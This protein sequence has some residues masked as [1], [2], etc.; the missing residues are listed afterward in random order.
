M[1]RA[2]ATRLPRLQVC[3]TSDEGGQGRIL[4]GVIAAQDP[5]PFRCGL[6]A[7]EATV[8]QLETE[9]PRN[10]AANHR[11]PTRLPHDTRRLTRRAQRR[12]PHRSARPATAQLSVHRRRLPRL[13]RDPNGWAARAVRAILTNPRYTGHEVWGRQRRDYD[14]LD[15]TAPADGTYGACAG[16]LATAGSGH[17]SPRTRR[18]STAR[19][20]TES[21]APRAAC[22]VP[23]DAMRRATYCAGA[24]AAR[25]LRRAHDRG[26]TK[27]TGAATTAANFGA[28]DPARPLTIP[29][30]RVRARAASRRRARPMAG[31][32]LF[33]PEHAATT[34][35]AIV[36]AA[37]YDPAH[38]AR[39]GR[40]RDALAQA[41][42]RL[43]Q[44]RAAL[45][46]GLIRRPLQR[47]SPKP[48]PK[49]EQP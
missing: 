33:A 32:T 2:L 25:D 6:H 30:G 19:T 44:Y 9:T 39:V 45:D 40:V 31:R 38:Q 41:R 7:G 17:R 43:A 46:A 29:S 48:R 20:G 42:R 4:A 21:R 12:P 35:Q 10:P 3:V 28:T 36:D 37:A 1:V 34:A 13:H 47:G 23:N 49:S 16:T 15:P 11:S 24:S 8:G 14:L 5:R 26:R 18:S 22:L 27:A